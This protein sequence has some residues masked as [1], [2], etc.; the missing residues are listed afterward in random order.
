MGEHR[1]YRA[2]CEDIVG[3]LGGVEVEEVSLKTLRDILDILFL[4]VWKRLARTER[5]PSWKFLLGAAKDAQMT[6][7]QLN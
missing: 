5:E 1:R 7:D 3:N 6:N 4:S 2:E